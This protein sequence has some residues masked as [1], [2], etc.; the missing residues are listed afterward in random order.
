MPN[1]SLHVAVMIKCKNMLASISWQ[2]Y[3]TVVTLFTGSYYFYIAL[4]YYRI[5]IAGLV[6]G[7]KT[8][9]VNFPA[10]TDDQASIIGKTKLDTI[11][12]IADDHEVIY[13]N[14]ASDNNEHEIISPSPLETALQP[15]AH[16]SS[17]AILESDIKK[18][19]DTASSSDDKVG[20]LPLLRALISSFKKEN[21]DADLS[22]ILDWTI[23]YAN[24]KLSFNLSLA[25]LYQERK[26]LI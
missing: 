24:E 11:V 17:T 5:E 22:L 18:L 9:S 3:L 6:T 8:T 14:E 26:E 7:K 2:Q 19:I 10:M 4:R 21:P 20:V 1:K 13:S 16:T 15:E 25:D 23:E 12:T